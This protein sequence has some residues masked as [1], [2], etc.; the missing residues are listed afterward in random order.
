MDKGGHGGHDG[1]G[2]VLRASGHI[3]PHTR[4]GIGV[5]PA[6]HCWAIAAARALLQRSA[7]EPRHTQQRAVSSPGM[8][9]PRA[10][11]A[12]GPACHAGPA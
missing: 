12:Q 9:G 3:L 10:G 7:A 1:A 11:W 2:G 4:T 6:G 8:G 5:G